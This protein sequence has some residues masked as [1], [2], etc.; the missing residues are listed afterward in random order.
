M[1]LDSHTRLMT[2]AVRF[3]HQLE[4]NTQRSAKVT[5]SRAIL[6]YSSV[7]VHFCDSYHSVHTSNMT[8]SLYQNGFT[9]KKKISKDQVAV[10]E[11]KG[12]LE[13]SKTVMCEV[14]GLLSSI[15]R[16]Q[17][18][19]GNSMLFTPKPQKRRRGEIKYRTLPLLGPEV[20]LVSKGTEGDGVGGTSQEL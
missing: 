5:Y 8:L 1:G 10:I 6:H 3:V 2:T 9:D 7:K 16:E 18:S 13:T 11:V 14:P 12:S 17:E 19:L 15:K 4:E 20:L